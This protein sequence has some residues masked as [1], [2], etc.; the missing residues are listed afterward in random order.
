ME[1]QHDLAEAAESPRRLPWYAAGALAGI[2]LAT[3]VL[4]YAFAAFASSEDV[5]A[6]ETR[7][8]ALEGR[9]T[10]HEVAIQGIKTQQEIEARQHQFETQQLWEIARTVGARTLPAPTEKR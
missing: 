2:T 6:V 8:T 7:A 1:E 9:A 5:R 4:V 10:A 3:A